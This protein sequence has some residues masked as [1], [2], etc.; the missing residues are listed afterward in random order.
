VSFE[1]QDKVYD[2]LTSATIKASPAPSLVGVISGD[3]VTLGT[4]AA[5]ASFADKNVGPGKTV[6]G[7][8]FT[9]SGADAGNYAFENPQGTTTADITAKS[10]HVSFEAQDKVRSEERRVGNE[11]RPAPSLDGVIS[12]DTVTL[13]TGAASA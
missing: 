5:S 4:G 8:G 2:A 10:V 3:T 9:K 12:G 6:T 1:A 13:W 7:S 11:G